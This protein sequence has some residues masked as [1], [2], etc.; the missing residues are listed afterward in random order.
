MSSD[1]LTNLVLENHDNH[2]I[3]RFGIKHYDDIDVE[4]IREQLGEASL[5]EFDLVI[6]YDDEPAGAYDD[7]PVDALGDNYDPDE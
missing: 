1:D 6:G 7:D 4:W 5:A 2:D 3:V